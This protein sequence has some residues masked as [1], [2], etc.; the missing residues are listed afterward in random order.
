M[1]KTV[2]KVRVDIHSEPFGGEGSKLPDADFRERFTLAG[3]TDD[4]RDGRSVLT[5]AGY[6]VLNPIPVSPPMGYQPTPD[7]MTLVHQQVVAH[8][9]QLAESDEIDS[10]E[11]FDD[12]DLPEELDPWSIYEV[13]EMVDEAPALPKDGGT[14]EPAPTPPEPSKK[15]E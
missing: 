12:F 2:E 6:E 7:M 5:D 3:W 4:P 9:R 8:L 11:E 10:E 13:R 1:S 14:I 15:P